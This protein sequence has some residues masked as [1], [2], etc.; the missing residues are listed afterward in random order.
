MKNKKLDVPVKR[1]EKLT[2]HEKMKPITALL[3]LKEN[4]EYVL[5]PLNSQIK[6]VL[7][8]NKKEELIFCSVKK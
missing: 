6:G 3:F 7:L 8:G 4:G 1:F 2:N 5:L